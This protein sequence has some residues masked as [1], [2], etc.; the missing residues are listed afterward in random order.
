MPGSPGR[1]SSLSFPSLR[2]CSTAAPCVL[3]AT[4]A[5]ALV[6]AATLAPAL[7]LAA[8]L[9]PSNE[10]LCRARTSAPRSASAP[11]MPAPPPPVIHQACH[12]G[13]QRARTDSHLP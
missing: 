10:L 13:C 6:L 4:L 7:V 1:P 5:P 9:A 2:A 3:A 8:T 11:V 12:G